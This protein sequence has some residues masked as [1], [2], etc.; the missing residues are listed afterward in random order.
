MRILQL[1]RRV[2][3]HASM[4]LSQMEHIFL[5]SP[6]SDDVILQARVAHR[7]HLRD[8]DPVQVVVEEGAGAQVVAAG[9]LPAEAGAAAAGGLAARGTAALGE[10]V[11]VLL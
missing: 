5:S 11:Y 2:F 4:S 9:R 3:L 1:S 8:A 7:V 6:V 10:K